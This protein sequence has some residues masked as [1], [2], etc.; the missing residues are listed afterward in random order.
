MDRE[1]HSLS[2]P[3]R[4]VRGCLCCGSSPLRSETTVVS[5]FFAKKAWG[6]KPELTKVMFCS[7]CGFRFFDRGLTSEEASNYYSDYRGED[8][9]RQRNQFEPFYTEKAHRGIQEWLRSK[10]RRIALAQAL[11]SAGGPAS[12]SAALDYGGGTG[13]MLV[14]IPATRKAVFDLAHNAT[15]PGIARIQSRESIG[16][17]WDLVLSCQVLEHVS[18]PR[19]AVEEIMQILAKGGWFYVEVPDEIWSCGA[20]SG[21]RRDA[22]LTWMST[23]PW[24][25]LIADCVSTACRVKLGTLPSMGFVPMREHLNYFTVESLSKLLTGCGLSVEWSGKNL[26]NCICAVGRRK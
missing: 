17:G 11:A 4:G 22:W 20:R 3:G 10:G 26:Q 13:Q 25:L 16:C 23:R 9:F 14:D 6:G 8:Y 24:P 7:G 19:A 21:P 18:D 15:E 2:H 1:P 5:P 12:F